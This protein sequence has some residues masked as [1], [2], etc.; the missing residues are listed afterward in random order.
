MNYPV[1]S[2]F[3]NSGK[4]IEFSKVI[5]FFEYFVP[6]MYLHNK[7]LDKNKLKVI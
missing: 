4:S 5:H 3:R 2:V 1:N 6:K 7:G